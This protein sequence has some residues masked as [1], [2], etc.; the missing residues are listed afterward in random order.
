ML[1][2]ATLTAIIACSIATSNAQDDSPMLLVAGDSWGAFGWEPLQKVL[3]QHGSD[4]VVKN[5]AIGGG[6]TRSHR[7]PSL[8]N[9]AHAQN[10]TKNKG[11]TSFG[12]ARD[13][14]C[15]SDMVDKNPTTE[16]I[17]L[18]LGGNDVIDFMPE[19]TL[20]HPIDDCINILL[21]KVINNTSFSVPSTPTLWTVHYVHTLFDVHLSKPGSLP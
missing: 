3:T 16:Y 18:S 7:T 10:K 19:C 20:E 15:L 13:P 1:F 11:T 14:T 21:P 5:Y 4:L 12:W 2:L 8:P 6:L 9:P 17:W